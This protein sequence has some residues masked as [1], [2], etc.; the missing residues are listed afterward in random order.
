MKRAFLS[1]AFCVVALAACKPT[2]PPPPDAGDEMFVRRATDL[3]WGRSP[4]GLAEVQLLHGFLSATDRPT[5]LRMMA[6]SPEYV[7]H[8][9]EVVMDLLH[10]NR[11]GDRGNAACYGVQRS[12]SVDASLAAWVRDHAPEEEGSPFR[13]SMLDLLHSSIRLDDLSPFFRANLFAQLAKDIPLQGVDSALIVEENLYRTFEETYLNREMACLTCHNSEGAVTDSDD[14]ES[15]R[16]HP[17]PGRP[18][19]AI[20][21]DAHGRDPLDLYTLF[22]KHGVLSGYDIHDQI[23][24]FVATGCFPTMVGGCDHCACEDAVCAIDPTCCSD[25]WEQRCVDLCQQANLGCAPGVP[26]GWHGCS[27]LYGYPGCDGCACEFRVCA[28]DPS[29]CSDSWSETCAIQCRLV[30]ESCEGFDWNDYTYGGHNVWGLHESCGTFL[31]P[32]ELWPD[33]VAIPSFLIGDLGMD[34]SVYD[35]DR[36][37]R[38]GF[39]E[40][41]AGYSLGQREAEDGNAALAALISQRLADGVWRHVFG[42][43]LTIANHFPRNAA[44]GEILARLAAASAD[45]GLALLPVLVALSAEPAFNPIA[46]ADGGEDDPYTFEPIANP[47]VVEDEEP[48]RRRNSVGD[49]VHRRDAR[50]LVRSANRAM[51]LPGWPSFPADTDIGDEGKLQEQLGFFLKDSIHG[52]TG[53]DFQGLSA[54]EA[55]FGSCF[56]EPEHHD[57]CWPRSGPGC[58]GCACEE[59]VCRAWPSCCDVRWDQR[60]TRFCS[61]TG[62]GC[63]DGPE[64][65][66]PTPAWLPTLVAEARL[67]ADGGEDLRLI[68]VA[69]ALK[70]RILADP[71]L[72]D[73]DEIAA[74]EALI[75]EP[76]STPINDVADAE[77]VVRPYC[78]ALLSTP[79]FQLWG[80][81]GPP[82]IDAALPAVLSSTATSAALCERLAAYVGDGWVRCEG[83]R[84]APGSEWS[85][86]R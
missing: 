43:G 36:P 2:I 84:A 28:T 39:D 76:L 81:A 52:F 35:L 69:I 65:P 82:R 49:F 6:A 44:Q 86:A 31:T 27:S 19:A 68:D 40:L 5:L 83:G 24:G 67:R 60:C 13:F 63:V 30:D 59:A 77:S 10:I 11:T 3:M 85:G 18:E 53:N 57:G 23:Y 17:L 4:E 58:L 66:P 33:P 56:A 46:P 38:A 1:W 12:E 62:L 55:A 71:V 50:V 9:S 45:G 75:G 7:D 73:P 37:M 22:R 51:G 48:A 29:C 61:L 74:I 47:W 21:G 20:F 26:D 42:T 14:P 15:D 80:V 70:D 79:H 64:A 54:W 8:W 32:G 16:H 72:D 25:R 41:R 78:G 34:A